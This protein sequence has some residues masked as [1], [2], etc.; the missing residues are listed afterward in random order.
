[1]RQI[2]SLPNQEQAQRFADYLLTLDMKSMVE[3]G[4]ENWLVWIYEEDQI[5]QAKLE[6]AAFNVAP[7]DARYTNA[8][9]EATKLRKQ[10]AKAVEQTRRRTVDARRVWMR[11]ALARSPVTFT[12]IAICIAVA[13]LTEIS[14][15][16]R[17]YLYVASYW[18]EGN[19]IKWRGLEDIQQGEIWR[20]VTPIFMHA[21][22]SE[23]IGILHILF[24]MMWMKQLGVVVEYRR[25]RRRYILI[26]L[27]IAIA[28]N[29]GQY[30]LSGPNFAGMSG[31]VFGLF[32]YIWMRAKFQ[33][34]SGFYMPPNLVFWM[35]AF[36]FLC[37]TGSFGP[38]A[39]AAHGVGLG[40]GMLLGYAPTVW[41]RPGTRKS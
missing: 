38:I 12:I 30:V 11:P 22:I 27:T 7:D 32:G 28:S 3:D 18:V 33:P 37:F 24:N 31:V 10:Q 26:L 15:D 36:F 17:D 20:L 13:V 2:G 25:G 29:L 34:D 40:T 39:N 9:H 14:P 21:R 16:I 19:Y 5:D 1:M 4:G 41:R 35:L 23:G 6:L 8:T